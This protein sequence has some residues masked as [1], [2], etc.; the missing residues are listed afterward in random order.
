MARGDTHRSESNRY[1]Y[2]AAGRQSI[3]V[4]EAFRSG[5]GRGGGAPP[6][7][8]DDEH[9]PDGRGLGEGGRHGRTR[10]TGTAGGPR[11]GR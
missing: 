4:S 11:A 2:G 5:C 1:G 7:A 8:A 6:D 9:V 10:T 3:P